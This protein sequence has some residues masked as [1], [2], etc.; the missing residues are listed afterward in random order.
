M[1]SKIYRHGDVLVLEVKEIPTEAT[2]EKRAGDIILAHGEVTG[3]AHR[4]K[5]KKAQTFVLG[6]KRY[7]IIDREAALTH[8]EH[9]RIDLPQGNYEVRIQRAYTPEA[10]VRV[11]D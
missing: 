9:N 4:I 8:E 11:A 3:H 2:K 7:L 5:E 10:I 1:Q 6:D